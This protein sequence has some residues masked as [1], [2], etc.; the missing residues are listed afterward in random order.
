M[1]QILPVLISALISTP[2][3]W[4]GK[5]GRPDFKLWVMSVPYRQSY[6][7]IWGQNPIRDT[8]F[9][10][11]YVTCPTLSIIKFLV[12]HIPTGVNSGEP[13]DVHC[14]VSLFSSKI[15]TE[16]GLYYRQNTSWLCKG[17]IAR[18]WRPLI[19]QDGDWSINIHIYNSDLRRGIAS[20]HAINLISRLSAL[21]RSAA[22]W[23][24]YT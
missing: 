16:N 20:G 18:R 12:H 9:H 13:V 23:L 2:Y 11:L 6:R 21:W 1:R 7:Q 22:S 15:H 17:H 10:L 19:G 4:L 8:F 3:S 14:S 24:A 5:E